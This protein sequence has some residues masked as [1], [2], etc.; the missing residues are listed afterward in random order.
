MNRLFALIS[1]VVLFALG[2]QIKFDVPQIAEVDDE[3]EQVSSKKNKKQK[4]SD[5]PFFRGP[6]STNV[7]RQLR[8]GPSFKNVE[9]DENLFQDVSEDLAQETPQNTEAEVDQPTSLGFQPQSRQNSIQRTDQ[10]SLAKKSVSSK[11]NSLPK[12]GSG[13]RMGGPGNGPCLFCLKPPTDLPKEDDENINDGVSSGGGGG[14]SSSL[15]CSASVGSGSFANPFNV[16][17]S[18]STAAD[19]KFIISE[20]IC[21]DP[22]LGSTYT[23]TFTVNPGAGSYCLS[24]K[25]T[26]SSGVESSVVEKFYTFNPALPDI[27]IAHTKTFFNQQNSRG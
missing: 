20:T 14:G 12:L 6:A 18:C 24:L 27:Q 4:V 19:I 13:P 8:E 5:K 15:N 16:T 1:F 25:G 3:V 2:I 22:D 21:G 9:K 10:N 11:I 7:R 26:T 23:S 17:L